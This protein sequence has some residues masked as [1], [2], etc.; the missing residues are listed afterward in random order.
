MRGS[1]FIGTGAVLVVSAF[2]ISGQATD[3]PP[4]GVYP[5]AVVD[6]SEAAAAKVIYRDGAGAD[7]L[8]VVDQRV[9]GSE[10]NK[11][12]GVD[13]SNLYVVRA[14]LWD[15]PPD[16]LHHFGSVIHFE[17]HRFAV[18]QLR[19]EM[20]AQLS[21]LLHFEGMACGTLE[22][23]D[24][25]SIRLSTGPTPVPILPVEEKIDEVAAIAAQVN[26]GN[27]QN[28]IEKL[29]GLTTRYHSSETGKAVATTLAQDYE[30]YRAGREDVEISTFPH[31]SATPQ[32]SLVV[33]IK[34]QTLPNEIVV[35]GSHID[36][37][38]YD[39]FGGS[40][41]SPGA[42]DNAS[43]TATNLEVFRLLMAHGI[44]PERTIEIH[45]YAAEEIG[46]VGSKDMA[47]K[48]R[49][50]SKNV[51][52]MVQHDMNIY[53]AAGTADKIWFVTNS[54]DAGLN[55]KL[56]KLVDHYAG[57]PWGMKVLTSGSSDHAS[58][59][60]QGYPAAFPF[61]DPAS[62]NRHIHSQDDS[63]ANA[64][65][66]SQAAAFAKLGFSYLVHFAGIER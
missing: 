3:K 37:V 10:S 4:V 61:E 24:E 56:A 44:R 38:S 65:A 50:A 52:S 39:G 16:F 63:T 1:L 26:S 62:Y 2:S 57:V 55:E 15:S 30:R 53:K 5:L 35:L 19:P 14:S 17:P 59:T 21:G 46:L 43:G 51:I 40:G 8:V 49:A 13:W 32:A 42:D 64:A 12:P 54:T 36:S 23:I 48:Y 9:G 28:T 6:Q 34:G 29:S 33:R 20:V 58:W 7:E 47:Q 11:T 45:G 27:I 22:K 18:M 25:H 41:R 60:R 31:G 66:Y